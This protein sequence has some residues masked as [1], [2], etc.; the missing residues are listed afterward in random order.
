MST[1]ETMMQNILDDD[2]N[3]AGNV[4]N[5]LIG[6]KVTDALEQEKASIAANI[7]GNVETGTDVDDTLETEVEVEHEDV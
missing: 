4:F 1:I 6:D 2:Y 7:Y 5:S 3:A